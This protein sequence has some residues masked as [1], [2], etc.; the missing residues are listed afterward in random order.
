MFLGLFSNIIRILLFLAVIPAVV[1]LV[2]IYRLD[3]LEKEPV[4]FVV[5]L[6]GLGCLSTVFAVISE[7]IFGKVLNLT[8]QESSPWY[9]VIYYFIVVGLSEEGFKYLLLHR[10]TW[11]AREFNCRFD[12]IVYAVS[13]S[14]GFALLENIEYVFAYGISTAIIRALTA[15]PGHCS[16][17]ILMGLLYSRAK[18]AD[19]QKNKVKTKV[20]KTLALIVPTLAHGAYDYIA[21]IVTGNAQWYF[22]AFIAVL[23]AMCFIT[24]KRESKNDR[25][26][27]KKPQNPD[28]IFN[29][30]F[31]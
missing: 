9:L 18:E 27:N 3:R 31:K 4:M 6:V 7:L 25:Y 1:L 14:L 22:I 11:R 26:I 19:Y 29:Q 8:I 28:D 23:F 24:V 16:F 17:G 12:G 2:Y 10:K 15:V 30:L 20:F 13:V 21:T 5:A